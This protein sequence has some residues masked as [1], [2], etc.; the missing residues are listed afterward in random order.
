MN[1]QNSIHARTAHKHCVC[2][3]VFFTHTH[4]HKD[5]VSLRGHSSVAGEQLMWQTIQQM[6]RERKRRREKE[7]EKKREVGGGGRESLSN[8]QL[9]LSFRR[10]N[11]R[12]SSRVHQWLAGQ[13]MPSAPPFLFFCIV[14][15]PLISLP[16]PPP[17]LPSPPS[18]PHLYMCYFTFISQPSV[19]GSVQGELTL[20]CLT[21]SR[22]PFSPLL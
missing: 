22:R 17:S 14:I 7:R 12:V 20:F 21:S 16:P 18:L 1:L 4:T 5:Y 13:E 3:C 8:K 2:V 19:S 11:V 6:E 15:T 9:Q 10:T